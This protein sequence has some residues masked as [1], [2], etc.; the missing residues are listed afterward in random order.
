MNILYFSESSDEGITADYDDASVD[1]IRR[2]MSELRRQLEMERQLR[3][4]LECK[5]HAMNQPPKQEQPAHLHSPVE[6]PPLKPHQEIVS[7]RVDKIKGV[8]EDDL[9]II[10][11]YMYNMIPLLRIVCF[12][13]S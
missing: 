6:R 5:A 12:G 10:Y 3:M 8:F 9:G 7:R 13:N 1:E 2:E 4:I 11:M